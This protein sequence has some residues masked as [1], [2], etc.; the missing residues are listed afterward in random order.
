MSLEVYAVFASIGVAFIA[1][2]FQM[3]Q[4]GDRKCETLETQ[5]NDLYTD[6]HTKQLEPI[7]IQMIF[8]RKAK[9]DPYK[10]MATPE[11]VEDW[12]T[13]KNYLSKYMEL[14]GHRYAIFFSISAGA[15]I[16]IIDGL[17]TVFLAIANLFA[18]SNPGLLGVVVDLTYLMPVVVISGLLFFFYF[19]RQYRQ[20][21][22][23]YHAAVREL[24][25]T[26]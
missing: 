9:Q 13:F 7:V 8:Q 16:L 25:R 26:I 18:S 17:L 19:I 24:R 10:F 20:Y 22:E 23:K 14:D 12:R 21:M 3:F 2:G 1:I 5:L 11:V 4:M 6:V 15:G